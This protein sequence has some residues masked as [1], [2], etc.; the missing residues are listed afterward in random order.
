MLDVVDPS[1][2]VLVDDVDS[3]VDDDDDDSLVELDAVDEPSAVSSTSCFAVFWQVYRFCA[4]LFVKC[5]ANC[6]KQN[7]SKF[8]VLQHG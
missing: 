6:P 7:L 8:T 2:N 4:A 1:G 5:R 3:A